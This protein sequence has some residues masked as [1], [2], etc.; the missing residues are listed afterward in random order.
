MPIRADQSYKPSAL[1]LTILMLFVGVMTP[2][3]AGAAEVS[4]NGKRIA[5]II[6]FTGYDTSE[7]H[8][9]KK[10]FEA[11]GA[12]V[13]VVSTQ[14]GDAISGG[15]VGAK[16]DMTIDQLNAMEYDAVIFVGGSGAGEFYDNAKAHAVAKK[17]LKENKVL[18]SICAASTT[19]AKAGVLKGK[20]ATGYYKAP[21]VEHGGHYSNQFVVKD[22]NLITAIGPNVVK[23]FTREI[24]LALQ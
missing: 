3:S 17:L 6:G 5:M 20:Q 21:I 4:L 13:H 14:I 24:I 12:T 15:G 22:G 1:S 2:I 9:P 19:L 8:E 16:V 23:E 11:K 10:A 7:L 18:A